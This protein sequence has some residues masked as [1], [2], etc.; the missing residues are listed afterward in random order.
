MW[1]CC[2]M[3]VRELLYENMP[4]HNFLILTKRPERLLEYENYRKD[5]AWGTYFDN[6]WAGISISNQRDLVEMMDSFMETVAM[7][8]FISI[9]PMLEP[10]KIDIYIDYLRFV[11]I[12]CESGPNRRPFKNE[13]A[14]TI[15]KTCLKR[16][17]PVFYKQGIENGKLTHYPAINGICY[18]QFPR[19][20]L[21]AE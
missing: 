19:Q 16:N 21:E 17:V 1:A 9:E 12:G 14:E 5:R 2:D 3:P 20:L 10:I 18:Q 13:W 4:V 11:I 6:I 8:K 15:V 7:N